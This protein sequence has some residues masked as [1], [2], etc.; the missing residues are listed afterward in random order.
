MMPFAIEFKSWGKSE[1]WWTEYV[2]KMGNDA[3]NKA[4]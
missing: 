3:K 2:N 4:K 1:L